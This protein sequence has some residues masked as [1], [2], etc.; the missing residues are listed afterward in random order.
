MFYQEVTL[1][2]FFR[3]WSCLKLWIPNYWTKLCNC[4]YFHFFVRKK[5]FNGSQEITSWLLCILETNFF[6]QKWCHSFIFAQTRQITLVWLCL[7]RRKMEASPI[8]NVCLVNLDNCSQNHFTNNSSSQITSSVITVK[9]T[10]RMTAVELAYKKLVIWT[11]EEKA[12]GRTV[13]N[14]SPFCCK[15]KVS[16]CL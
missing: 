1:C 11:H 16:W 13:N 14:P 15:C 7:S 8:V 2:L 5:L 12:I 9:F 10:S 4:R 3:I 6:Y